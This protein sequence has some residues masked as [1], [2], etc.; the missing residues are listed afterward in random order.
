MIQRGWGEQLV[1]DKPIPYFILQS[2]INRY[3]WAAQFARGKV[4]LDAGCGSGYGANYLRSIGARKVIGGDFSGEAV[5]Y[6]IKHYREEGLNF[7]RLDA[8]QLPFEDKTFDII[9]SFE[10]IEHMRKYDD[11]IVECRRVLKD[12]GIFICSTP[13][14][15]TASPDSQK[16]R[17]R[18][19]IREF[20]PEELSDLISR[21]FTDVTLYGMDPQSTA[22]KK[23]YRLAYWLEPKIF[24]LPKA[25][26]FL[27]LITRFVFRRYH[28]IKLAEIKETDLSQ[29]LDKN[30]RPFLL[31]TS[32]LV[33]GDTIAVA[34]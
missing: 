8:Q 33:P 26:F 28:L 3:V 11:F 25:H 27:N 10:S 13:N 14:K 5:E 6:A 34:R 32:S 4:I 19:H 17:A 22:D 21:H 29:I 9:I 20:Y 23:I 15:K 2:S 7:V 18:Y 31:K 1:P 16:P 12:G 30:Y 24:Y